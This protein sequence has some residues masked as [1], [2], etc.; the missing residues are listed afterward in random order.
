MKWRE[1]EGSEK[2]YFKYEWNFFVSKLFRHQRTEMKF[3]DNFF[4]PSHPI[5]LFP[6]IF[7]VDESK[8]N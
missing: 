3:F 6:S 1:F 2:N 4:V 5:H 8:L 7:G